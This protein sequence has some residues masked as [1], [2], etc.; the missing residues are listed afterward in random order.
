MQTQ[1]EK[2]ETCDYCNHVLDAAEV[3]GEEEGMMMH[4][5]CYCRFLSL[6]YPEYYDMIAV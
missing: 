3:V 6:K 2:L 5:D 1:Q 4:I